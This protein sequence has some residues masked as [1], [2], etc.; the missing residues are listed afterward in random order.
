VGFILEN[1]ASV[2]LMWIV[3]QNWR[4]GRR[5][6]GCPGDLSSVLRGI[7]RIRVLGQGLTE[8][9]ASAKPSL[10]TLPGAALSVV[11]SAVNFGSPCGTDSPL[12]PSLCQFKE[13]ITLS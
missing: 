12:I 7:T 10:V 11:A 4:V 1:S 8:G 5:K 13:N 9:S 3:Q 6:S 2:M